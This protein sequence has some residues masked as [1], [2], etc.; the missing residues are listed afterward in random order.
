VLTLASENFA[1]TTIAPATAEQFLSSI[2]AEEQDFLSRIAAA[3]THAADL[4]IFREFPFLRRGVEFIPMDIGFVMDKAG[5]SL[6]WTALKRCTG[7]ERESLLQHWGE[8]FER[9]V[10]T[11]LAATPG[12]PGSAFFDAPTFEDG[13][14]VCDGTVR[15][16]RTLILMEYKASTISNTIKYADNPVALEHVLETRFVAGEGHGRKGLAQISH[17]IKRFSEG[18]AII[19]RYSGTKIVAEDVKKIIPVLVHLDNA[20]RTPGIPHY[21]AGRFK[22]LGRAKQSWRSL[23]GISTMLRYQHFLNHL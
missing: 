9:H 17:A 11:V 2:S 16:G 20:L 5:R 4:T 21:M 3:Q 12:P 23:R 13:A 1:T 10:S 22:S 18:Q 6:F 19:D 8:L 14:Q 7:A 15:E